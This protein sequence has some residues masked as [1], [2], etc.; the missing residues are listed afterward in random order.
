MESAM[1]NLER[2]VKKTD[3]ILD[4]IVW[5]LDEFEKEITDDTVKA[6]TEDTVMNLLDSVTQVRE[7]Y[8]HLRREL[9]QVQ[10]LQ[11]SVRAK[12]RYKTT[13]VEKNMQ[14]LR[15]KLSQTAMN[16]H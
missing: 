2:S 5:K 7:D 13:Q 15:L 8:E 9:Q 16:S 10:E 3:G 12:L 4:N 6:Q 1:V 14:E 11:R